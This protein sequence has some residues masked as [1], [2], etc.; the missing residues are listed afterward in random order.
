[1]TTVTPDATVQTI[2]VALTPTV[3]VFREVV[4]WDGL[5]RVAASEVRDEMENIY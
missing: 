2:H 3:H 5:E 1:M 4:N